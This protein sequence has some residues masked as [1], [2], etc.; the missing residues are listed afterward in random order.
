[1]SD[2][3]A[4]NGAVGAVLRG[5][6][7]GW[8][9]IAG[10][11]L[12]AASVASAAGA[13]VK[14]ATPFQ[15]G[16][17]A[18]AVNNAG[19]AVIAWANTKDLAGA[20]N[21]VQ[22]CVL[23]AGAAGCSHSGNLMPADSAQ[24]I[25]GVQVLNEGSTLVILADVFGAPA[26]SAG[27]FTPEQEWQSTDGGATWVIL[28]GGR[29]VSTGILNADTEPVS[30]VTLPGTGALGYGWDTAGPSGPTFNA[31]PLNGPPECS[32][33]TCPA[34]F[35]SLEPSTNPDQLSN[36]PGEFASIS[37]GPLGGVMGVFET[38]FTNG[39]LG[40]AQDFGT[41]YVYGSGSQS[42]T[43]N[44][45]ISPG[46]PNSAWRV[47]V[48]QADCN[49]EYAAVGGGPSGFGILED[50]LTG[51]T[52]YHRFDAATEK[53]DTPLVVVADK[54]EQQAALSQDGSGGIYGTYLLGGVGGP[55]MLSYSADAGANW[56]SGTL[57][58]NSDGGV[59]SLNSAVNAAGKGW[60]TWL[61]NGSVFAQPFEAADAIAPATVGGGATTNGTAITVNVTCATFPCTIT[62]TLTAPETVVVHASSASLAL[63][64]RKKG[65]KTKKVTL[66]T[67]KFTLKSKGGHKLAVIL[68]PAG[69][70]F[71]RSH[72]GH[73]RISAKV[74]ELHGKV[75]TRTLELR[76]AKS[77]KNHKKK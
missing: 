26:N 21:F 16:P 73:V 67:G 59:A 49:T 48:T 35:A 17:P 6:T 23:P 25:D 28:N 57:D 69:R 77:G 58:K 39:P 32:R 18:I 31:F 61:D 75:T 24:F 14:V 3:K 9:V 41:A 29:S 40:C 65:K 27:D 50:Q 70:K 13:P 62:I 1:M 42:A 5:I 54:D 76:I 10:L 56:G 37:S 71:V 46:Q 33:A 47:A 38:L 51:R 55:V 20:D 2:S 63:G 43:N 45:N 8:L 68:S 66:G 15:S 30:A 72:S 60:V 22:Y 4:R 64:K 19:D 36:E 7:L 52:V 11:L 34:G 74:I 44:Y 12:A 53:F